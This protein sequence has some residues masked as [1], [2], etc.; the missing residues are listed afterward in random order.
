MQRRALER[1]D[2]LAA[3]GDI[4][5]VV[6]QELRDARRV[7]AHL[8]DELSGLL[9]VSPFGRTVGGEDRTSFI[10]SLAR[11]D[12][13]SRDAVAVVR[14]EGEPDGVAVS[15]GHEEVGRAPPVVPHVEVLMFVFG[16]R[17]EAV[18]LGPG[19]RGAPEEQHRH[20]NDRDPPAHHDQTVAVRRLSS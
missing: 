3:V 19:R 7:H 5:R 17:D 8:A 14:V 6:L 2:V 12:L 11:E 18:A 10:G 15:R 4:E 13:M 1:S 9:V 20:D 16:E